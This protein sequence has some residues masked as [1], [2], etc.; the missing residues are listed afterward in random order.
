MKCETGLHARELYRAK[1]GWPGDNICARPSG[2]S[3][4]F[5]DRQNN[6]GRYQRRCIAADETADA[7]GNK[8]RQRPCGEVYARGGKESRGNKDDKMKL[9]SDDAMEVHFL[10]FHIVSI[11]PLSHNSSPAYH[12]DM[13][14]AQNNYDSLILE[15]QEHSLLGSISAILGWD[16]RVCMPGGGAELRARQSSML[17]RMLHEKYTSPKIGEL[18]ASVEKTELTADKYGTPAVNIRNT[19]RRYDRATRVPAKL[20]EE[21]TSTEVLAQH[22]WGE[23]KQ[24]NDYPSF[25][26]WLEKILVLKRE[27]AKC[28]GGP[29]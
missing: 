2:K 1:R 26:P 29:V 9:R 10:C 17:A 5:C 22:A 4:R 20:V 21:L 25:R 8:N 19:R 23:A 6:A 14:T 7:P 24:K 16:E 27:Q 11:F 12:S 28:L 13:S 18:L 15:L 3:R